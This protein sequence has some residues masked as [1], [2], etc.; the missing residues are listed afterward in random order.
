[1]VL[2]KFQKGCEIIR[3]VSKLWCL[4]QGPL[5]LTC[6]RNIGQ[7]LYA[8]SIDLTSSLD[9]GGPGKIDSDAIAN[10]TNALLFSL[11]V[12][13]FNV[14]QQFPNRKI[15]TSPNSIPI[16]SELIFTLELDK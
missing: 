13:T 11:V 9:L 2:A 3:M 8:S 4:I 6:V 14:R 12:S 5:G 10:Q 7:Q 1:M 16:L 15:A